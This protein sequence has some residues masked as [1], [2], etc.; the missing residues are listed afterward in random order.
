VLQVSGRE[1]EL[2]LVG[3]LAIIVTCFSWFL[4]PYLIVLRYFAQ[5]PASCPY[6]TAVG[7]ESIDYFNLFL[8]YLLSLLIGTQV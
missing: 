7:G 4:N 2:F 1:E 8:I 5:F 6:V 3:K